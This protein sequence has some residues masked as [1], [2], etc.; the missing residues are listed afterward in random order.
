MND[1]TAFFQC[2][3]CR[4]TVWLGGGKHY[5]RDY[6]PRTFVLV[7]MCAICFINEFHEMVDE[8]GIEF[9][10]YYNDRFGC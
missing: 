3:R 2:P 4:E 8:R 1:S 10:D 5:V 6:H 9:V 7:Y